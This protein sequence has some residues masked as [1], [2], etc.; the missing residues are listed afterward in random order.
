[1][2]AP[3]GTFRIENLDPGR[4]S[5]QAM[6]SSAF[7]SLGTGQDWK[8]GKGVDKLDTGYF[9]RLVLNWK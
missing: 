1:V 9:T 8:P 6:R 5:V 4:Y 3:D 2:I 7:T